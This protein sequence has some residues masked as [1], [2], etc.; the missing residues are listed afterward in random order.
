MK[1]LILSGGGIKG[2][3]Y[4]GCLKYFEEHNQYPGIKT[5]EYCSF[6]LDGIIPSKSIFASGS[7]YI[8]PKQFA[9]IL[10]CGNGWDYPDLNPKLN[11]FPLKK[12]NEIYQH[13]KIIDDKFG[14]DEKSK[15]DLYSEAFSRIIDEP[16]NKPPLCFGIIGP[17]NFGKSNFMH[18]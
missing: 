10:K 3:A 6:L 11:N 9:S 2:I 5:K 17:D 14:I 18:K 7:Q 1:N 12:N 15:F 16:E 4:I 8:I 13:I